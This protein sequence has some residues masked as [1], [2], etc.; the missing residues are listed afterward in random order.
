MIER[1]IYN[2][3]LLVVTTCSGKVTAD[4]MIKSEYWMVDNFS[5]KIMP[6]FNQVFD[7]MAADTDDIS[8]DDI[9]RVAHINIS[10]GKERG[11]FSMA[12]LAVRPYPLALARLHKLL[13][14]TANIRV[15][16]FSN[17]DDAY[18]WLGI[19]SPAV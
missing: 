15:E 16:I 13:S 1:K 18:Q 3:G 14:V 11:E 8:E 6:G 2:D 5:R 7:A 12:I 17:I 9:R 4:E 19:K 10:H